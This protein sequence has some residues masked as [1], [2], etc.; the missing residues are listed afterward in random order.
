MAVL[1]IG[2]VPNLDEATYAGLVVQM[3]PLMQAAPG[4]ISHSGGPHPDGGWRVVE[5]WETEEDGQTWF[6]ANVVPISAAGHRAE[7]DVPPAAHRLHEVGDTSARRSYTAPMDDADGNEHSEPV[8]VGSYATEGEAEVA[9]AKLRAFGIES[10]LDD[11]I[12]GGTIVVEGEP[13]VIVQVRAVDATDAQR[14]L[15][16]EE[17]PGQPDA[18]FQ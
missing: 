15:T 8:A 18:D 11:Q 7:A 2:E 10:A 3:R 6:E 9:Q 14:I 13:G 16:D 12:E 4:F 17:E 5:M 1:M